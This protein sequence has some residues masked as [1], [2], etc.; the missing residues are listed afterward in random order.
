MSSSPLAK[1]AKLTGQHL[2]GGEWVHS[3][4]NH[5]P[6]AYYTADYFAH[7]VASLPSA[8]AS[9]LATFTPGISL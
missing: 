8:S 4:G 3:S 7:S 9:L 2:I 6:S 1:Q 5:R